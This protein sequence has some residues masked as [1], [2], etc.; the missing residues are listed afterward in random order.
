MHMF[1][2]SFTKLLPSVLIT[3]VQFPA[4]CSKLY[5][6]TNNRAYS[7]QRLVGY[8]S[9]HKL[10]PHKKISKWHKH[11]LQW[12]GV[13]VSLR[14]G[15]GPQSELE[16]EFWGR[17]Q[18]QHVLGLF[19]DCTLSLVLCSFSWCTVLAGIATFIRISNF[20]Q[21]TLKYTIS[22]YMSHSKS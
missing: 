14:L 2:C 21:V 11:W 9:M 15:F 5:H 19:F 17:F 6:I 3:F 8:T 13:G 18:L 10:T 16:Y 22:T 7:S 20:S 1:P 4:P 12:R